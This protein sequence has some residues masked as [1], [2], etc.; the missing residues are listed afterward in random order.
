MSEFTPCDINTFQSLFKGRDDVFTVR[1]E[2]DGKSGY[3][4][5]YQFD[6]YHYRMH[7]MNGGTFQSFQQKSYLPGK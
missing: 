1:W 7:K 4:P 2:K 5:A 3:M 6:P